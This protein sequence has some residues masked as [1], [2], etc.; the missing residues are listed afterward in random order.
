MKINHSLII[1]IFLQCVFSTT[2]AIA[3]KS[4]TKLL[5]VVKVD[6][7]MSPMMVISPPNLPLDSLWVGCLPREV[8]TFQ[9]ECLAGQLAWNQGKVT[10]MGVDTMWVKSLTKGV[11]MKMIRPKNSST[12]F[13]ILKMDLRRYRDKEPVSFNVFAGGIDHVVIPLNAK[14]CRPTFQEINGGFDLLNWVIAP[15]T[16]LESYALNVCRIDD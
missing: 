15:E 3:Q 7:I 14:G 9:I 8:V 4:K 13:W 10:N 1:L 16:F 2:Q 12:S 11:K 5:R 6:T